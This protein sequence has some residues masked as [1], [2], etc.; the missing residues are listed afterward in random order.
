MYN[1]R[2]DETITTTVG[3]LLNDRSTTYLANAYTREVN[4]NAN[5]LLHNSEA[6]ESIADALVGSINTD[7]RVLIAAT[8]VLKTGYT[9]H[10]NSIDALIALSELQK[11]LA[12][13]EQV[14]STD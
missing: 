7:I 11:A 1:T 14:T 13:A 9:V 4:T 12:E 8:R 6:L 2:K 3:A 10:N 5:S